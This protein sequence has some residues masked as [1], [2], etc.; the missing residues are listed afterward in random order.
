[1]NWWESAWAISSN[2]IRT[3]PESGGRL[4]VRLRIDQLAVSVSQ[5][6]PTRSRWLETALFTAM[7]GNAS[8]S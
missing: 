3:A 5:E 1:M 7:A 6:C 8:I 4:A 2:K